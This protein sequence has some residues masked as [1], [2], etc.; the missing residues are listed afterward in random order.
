MITGLTGTIGNTPLVEIRR[1]S[2]NPNVRIL[3]KL[4]AFNPGGSVKDRATKYMIEYAEMHGDLSNGKTILEATSGNTGIGLAMIGAANGHKVV[5]VMPES[6]SIE[7]RKILK[8]LGAEI[9]LTPA[10]RGMD[11][12]IEKAREMSKD[13]RYF[14]TDQFSNPYN[15]LAHYETTG[16]EIW[17]Q[18]GGV[19]VFV[20][21]MGT[22]GTIMGA[23]GFLK[24]KNPGV[25][26]IGVEPHRD[27]PIQGL[28]N[29]EV[30][31]V[32]EIL[33][34]NEIDERFYVKLEDAIE[35]TRLLA[36]K[37]GIF[38]GMSSGAAMHAALETA[39]K[40]EKGAI[41]VILP[42]GGMKY[43]ST[44]LFGGE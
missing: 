13:D 21:G 40:M 7:R 36:K 42:D 44:S 24:E 9:I 2:T 29:M 19:D 27:T 11:G 15:V 18:S 25:R 14:L 5:L 32:P 23:G 43:L 41:A 20:A 26:I 22:C 10:E 4:E 6:M 31:M 37:E 17:D 8:A 28:K 33:D 12:A 38:A 39:K 34:A 35:V 30:N 16:P 1:I 3:A